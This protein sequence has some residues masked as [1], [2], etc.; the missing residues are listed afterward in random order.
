MYW[1]FT[2]PCITSLIDSSTVGREFWNW[3]TVQ[4]ITILWLSTHSWVSEQWALVK[5]TKKWWRLVGVIWTSFWRQRSSWSGTNRDP[6][7]IVRQQSTLC[8]HHTR[9]VEIDWAIQ[10]RLWSWET[11]GVS[12]DD[13]RVG[14]HHWSCSI[15]VR[16]QKTLYGRSYRQSIASLQMKKLLAC[17]LA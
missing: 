15:D 13:K 6:S 9:T 7:D 1:K 2:I 8:W 17:V 5:V 12:R 3:Q 16:Q 10:R 4:D 14:G 11:P